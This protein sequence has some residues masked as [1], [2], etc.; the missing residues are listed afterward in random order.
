M[1]SADIRV[2]KGIVLLF[3]QDQLMGE[4]YVAALEKA[5]VPVEWVT[6]ESALR[7]RLARADLPRPALVMVL[8]PR[9]TSM[10]PSELA[11]VALRLTTDA[12]NDDAPQKTTSALEES[13]NY[14]CEERSLSGR[15]R[16]VLEMYLIG[17]NDKQ[18]ASAFS[19]SATTVYEHWRR[20]AKK[21]KG[22][23]KSDV[24]N[25]FHRFL[26]NRSEGVN[27]R[28]PSSLAAPRRSGRPSEP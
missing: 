6:T 15:Q 25:D 4:S 23:H 12:G 10:R 7:S 13:L 24:V 26:A 9:E 18:I 3:T 17:N 14:Y 19:C 22:V 20:M 2:Q 16:Q 11:N 8:H 27:R 28:L 21:A 1:E 5:T